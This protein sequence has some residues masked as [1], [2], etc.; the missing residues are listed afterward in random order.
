MFLNRILATAG[1]AI[2]TAAAD[3]AA[4][5]LRSPQTRAKLAQ[6]ARAAAMQGARRLGRTVGKLQ[7]SLAERT[8]DE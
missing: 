2:L 5:E 6:A 7:R 1:K 4:A 8:T 3:K